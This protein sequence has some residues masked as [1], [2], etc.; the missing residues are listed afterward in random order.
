[1]YGKGLGLVYNEKS[2]PKFKRLL[3]LFN[4]IR[5]QYSSP[6]QNTLAN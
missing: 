2:E 6:Q 5:N 4:C 3:K 1:M